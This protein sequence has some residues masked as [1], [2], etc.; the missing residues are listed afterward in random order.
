[1]PT[2]LL[3]LDGTLTDPREGIVGCIRHAL[4]CLGCTPPPDTA[5]ER[6]IGP[7]LA[8]TFRELLPDASDARVAEAIERYRERF[9]ATGIFEN[10][11]YPGV[12]E[13]LDALRSRGL[14]TAI[15][16]SKPQVFAE[17][18]AE[19]FGLRPQLHAV[20]GSALDG[21][22][23]RK[24]E[25]LAHAIERE[26]VT[27]AEALMVGDRRFDVAGALANGMAAIGVTW[28]YGS[29]EELAN[30]GAGWL[31]DTPRDVLD[32]VDGHF[33]GGV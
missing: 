13:L 20:Y 33:T 3:D 18:I 24:E 12:P 26:G 7:P 23:G 4:E 27:P 9:R 11:V 28:G 14:R 8:D 1:M 10:R 2:V 17:R 16:T 5:L 32:V 30:A 31:C 29:R 22:L 25:L 21:G 6:H 19:H 15:A